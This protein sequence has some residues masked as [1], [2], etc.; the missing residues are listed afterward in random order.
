M[1]FNFERLF[2]QDN[3]DKAN[4]K[5]NEYL[6]ILYAQT[7]CLDN[8]DKIMEVYKQIAEFKNKKITQLFMEYSNLKYKEKTFEIWLA[9]YIG[10]QDVIEESVKEM[11]KWIEFVYSNNILH[12]LLL[13][14]RE[15]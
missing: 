3:I 9:Y 8:G 4:N 11:E 12:K 1:K 15:I 5:I 2:N 6:P 13:N 7:E 14:F 10:R